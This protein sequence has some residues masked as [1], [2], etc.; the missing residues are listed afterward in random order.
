MSIKFSQLENMDKPSKSLTKGEEYC[1]KKYKSTQKRNDAG[2]YIVQ[3]PTKKL[4]NLG[5]SKDFAKKRFN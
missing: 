2:E 1:E 3:M 4:V 5:D